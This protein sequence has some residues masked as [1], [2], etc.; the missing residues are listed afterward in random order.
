MTVLQKTEQSMT[1]LSFAI[2]I[3]FA[4]CLSVAT[5]NHIR[6]DF[7]INICRIK[8]HTEKHG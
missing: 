1:R 5:T 4:C 2:R 8:R 6:A 3:L 7:Q